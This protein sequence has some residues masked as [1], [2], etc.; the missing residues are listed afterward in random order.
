MLRMRLYSIWSETRNA[1]RRREMKK[2]NN[3]NNDNKEKNTTLKAGNSHL[4]CELQ[5]PAFC[6][7]SR[8]SYLFSM[9]LFILSFLLSC[10]SFIFKK[11]KRKEKDT[12][13][14][15]REREGERER[16]ERER[17]ERER[18]R[19]RGRKGTLARKAKERETKK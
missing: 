7:V 16:R 14:S 10:N 3:N 19:G 9:N 11:T 13:C 1:E 18:G 12:L 2:K 5:F 4:R 17:E 8:P 6:S 15:T